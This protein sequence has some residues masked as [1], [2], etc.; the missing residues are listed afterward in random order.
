V[1]AVITGSKKETDF[2]IEDRWEAQ[3]GERREGC[4]CEHAG[5]VVAGGDGPAGGVH[6]RLLKLS[7]DVGRQDEQRG[8][9]E[10]DAADDRTR[11]DRGDRPRVVCERK[12]R[13]AIFC[14]LVRKPGARGDETIRLFMGYVNVYLLN[15]KN[16]CCK[17]ESRE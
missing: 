14:F 15:S 9:V 13:I 7:V 10:T 4:G 11:A 2:G 17:S 16:N 6:K 5:G 3:H 8:E 1:N 12:G